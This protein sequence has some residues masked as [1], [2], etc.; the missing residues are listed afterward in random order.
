MNTKELISYFEKE[1]DK[2][3]NQFN[4]Y[5]WYKI[6]KFKYLTEEF[7]EKY[8]NKV[9]WVWISE[10][11]KLSGEFIHK[12]K[13]RIVFQLISK[14]NKINYLKYQVKNNIIS[15]EEYLKELLKS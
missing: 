3:I 12:F 9:N 6:S 7:I 4:N 15:N 14:Q 13:N 1:Y 11:Q 8:K 5:E 10:H 2:K